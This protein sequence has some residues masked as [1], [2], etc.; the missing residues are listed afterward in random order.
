MSLKKG[1]MLICR[2]VCAFASIFSCKIK[3]G[4]LCI[5]DDRGNL[6]VEEM[7]SDTGE[8]GFLSITL[9]RGAITVEL[10]TD[11]SFACGA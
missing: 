10:T 2:L 6:A 4:F 8:N 3:S 5:S 7:Y 1:K 9:L 11:T